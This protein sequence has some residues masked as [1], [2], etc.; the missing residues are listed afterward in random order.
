MIG[1]RIIVIV[2]LQ[3]SELGFEVSAFVIFEFFFENMFFIVP[4]NFNGIIF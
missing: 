3:F 2:S 1:R 4:F